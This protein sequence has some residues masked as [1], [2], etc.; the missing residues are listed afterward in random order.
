MKEKMQF[1]RIKKAA[2]ALPLNV[3]DLMSA[4]KA[5]SKR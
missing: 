2:E 5:S 1:I 4:Y 3:E